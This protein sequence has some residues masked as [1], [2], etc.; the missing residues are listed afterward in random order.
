[1]DGNLPPL[2][3][4]EHTN[5]RTQKKAFMGWARISMYMAP[6]EEG[7]SITEKREYFSKAKWYNCMLCA[8]GFWIKP[9]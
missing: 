3:S 1:M 7:D 6:V 4:S 5:A 2:K 8:I 9:I